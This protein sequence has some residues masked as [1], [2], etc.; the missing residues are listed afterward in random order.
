MNILVIRAKKNDSSMARFPYVKE[1]EKY[2]GVITFYDDGSK[3]E[4]WCDD[5]EMNADVDIM[6]SY[7]EL[8]ELGLLL[9]KIQEAHKAAH[10]DSKDLT[11]KF[12]AL[13]LCDFP[14]GDKFNIQ[15]MSN[16]N[17]DRLAKSADEFIERDFGMSRVIV[18]NND[19]SKRT[20]GATKT[21]LGADGQWD[22][23]CA[24]SS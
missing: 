4:W 11:R 18:L 16:K 22:A 20:H 15:L 10:P 21:L 6:S 5:R 12:V 14:N 3:E 13:W 23:I 24:D 19:G 17:W 8:N 7:D 9:R 2:D 1:Y